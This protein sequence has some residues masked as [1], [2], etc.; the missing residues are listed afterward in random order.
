MGKVKPRAGDTREERCARRGDLGT[1]RENTV[2]V[3]ARRRC[4]SALSSFYA[5]CQCRKFRI[6]D[7]GEE[8]DGVF[9]DF[10]EFVWESGDGLKCG[11]TRFVS[12]TGHAPEPS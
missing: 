4:N 9:S 11:D 2:G 10:I 6:P 7:H 1:L 8:L 3:K 12:L 5:F